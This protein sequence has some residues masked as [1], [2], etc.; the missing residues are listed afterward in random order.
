[1]RDGGGTESGGCLSLPND[2]A[3]RT[4]SS[5]ASHLRCV[6]EIDLTCV[7]LVF[8]FIHALN[9]CVC[10][11]KKKRQG[12]GGALCEDEVIATFGSVLA[13]SRPGLIQLLVPE[14]FRLCAL[15]HSP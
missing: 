7:A 2:A 13:D 6:L 9:V 4:P 11:P 10:V 1:M 12:W 8:P 15:V 3:W 14:D 5:A